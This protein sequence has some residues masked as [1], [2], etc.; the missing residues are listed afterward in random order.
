MSED[1]TL[2]RWDLIE[3]KV[4]G[5]TNIRKPA[6]SVGFHPSAEM[7]AVGFID[8]R[9]GIFSTFKISI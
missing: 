1:R 5:S 4:I 2:R 7:L 3:K 8:G 9:D 6:K